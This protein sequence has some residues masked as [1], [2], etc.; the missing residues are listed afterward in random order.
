MIL[1]AKEG[2]FLDPLLLDT[3]EYILFLT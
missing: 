1:K 2:S 3:I